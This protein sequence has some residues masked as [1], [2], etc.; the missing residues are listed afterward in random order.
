M[1]TI[2]SV[3]RDWNLRFRGTRLAASCIYIWMRPTWWSLRA[4]L[5][6]GRLNILRWASDKNWDSCNVSKSREL[7]AEDH[8]G[9]H[10]NPCIPPPISCTS[11]C[12]WRLSISSSD[13][14]HLSGHL[15]ACQNRKVSVHPHGWKNSCFS[16]KSLCAGA[17]HG[18]TAC[19]LTIAVPI[20]ADRYLRLLFHENDR[21][22]FLTYNSLKCSS[23]WEIFGS[24]DWLS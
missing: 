8:N 24:I 10:D 14:L 22:H 20:E 23:S 1:E 17:M 13:H 4:T 11:Q 21:T 16:G 9:M 18:A 3:G 5:I 15:S 12:P 7:I 19:C 2:T 6:L